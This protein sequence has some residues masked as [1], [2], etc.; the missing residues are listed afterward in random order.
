MDVTLARDPSTNL[1]D[2]FIEN[3]QVKLGRDIETAV[4]I[5]LGTD[6]EARP[7]DEVPG[8]DRG[9]WWADALNTDPNDRIGSR[10]WLLKGKKLTSANLEK[11]REYCIEALQWMIDDSIAA[12]IEV[13]TEENAAGRLGARIRIHRPGDD[14][15][16]YRYVDLW[17]ELEQVI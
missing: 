2:L 17:N 10:L 5:S 3:G 6:R 11:A 4:L 16:E 15:L 8:D 13:F 12:K 9:G 1:I 14:V 7:D